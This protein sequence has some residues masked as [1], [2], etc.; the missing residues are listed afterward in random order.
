MKE[1]FL[2]LAKDKTNDKEWT[3]IFPCGSYGEAAELAEYH[4]N[5]YACFKIEKIYTGA[6]YGI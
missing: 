1:V 5:S 4:V 3:V 2:L 6:K